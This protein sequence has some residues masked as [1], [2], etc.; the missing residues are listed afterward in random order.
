LLLGSYEVLVFISPIFYG[1][2]VA[3][4]VSGMDFYVTVVSKGSIYI[5]I[6]IYII[7]IE[8]ERER[9]R[10]REKTKYA[11]FQVVV[12]MSEFLAC[13]RYMAYL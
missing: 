13:H 3:V 11:R 8:R 6:Y 9:E 1:V 7:Y 5:Y 10:E 12:G 4:P 2:N